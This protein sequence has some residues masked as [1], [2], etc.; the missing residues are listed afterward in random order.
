MQISQAASISERENLASQ[1]RKGMIAEL[2]ASGF[3]AS[4]HRDTDKLTVDG[5]LYDILGALSD[6]GKPATPQFVS[7]EQTHGQP[8]DQTTPSSPTRSAEE[9][10]YSSAASN[11][12]IIDNINNAK[13]LDER[14]SHV[15]QLRIAIEKDL[16]AAGH[17]A[18]SFGGHDKLVINGSV[19]DLLFASKAVGVDTRIQMLYDGPPP[20]GSEPTPG[21]DNPVSAIFSFGGSLSNIINQISQS[22]DLEQRRELGAQ[23]QNQLVT[24]MQNAGMDA[25]A[26][27]DPDKIII[28]GKIY[29]VI[30]SLNAPGHTARLQAMRIA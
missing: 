2:N 17:N 25:S 30:Q 1:Y 20:G 27:A 3:K 14:I 11:Q 4:E 8:D 29:D 19:Y 6:V 21:T 13:T 15:D 12:H 10:V 26:H 18:Y 22:F 23:F 7:T 28:S 5:A 24:S 16:N 9:V